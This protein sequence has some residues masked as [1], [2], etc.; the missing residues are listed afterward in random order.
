MSIPI[1]KKLKTAFGRAA[2]AAG[3][4]TR[5]FRSK[6]VI[7]AF[8]RVNDR[9]QNNDLTCG[10]EKF[11]QFCEFFAKHFTVI[12]LSEQIA[13]CTAN[14]NM[15]GTLA[16]TFDDGYRDNFDVAAP[17]LRRLRLPAA[18]F[19]TTRFIGSQF[20]PPWDSHLEVQPGWMD[21]GQVRAL[22][23]Q[24]FEIGCHTDS[25]IDMGT[26]E[27]GT[28][29]RELEAAKRK[30]RDELD[31]SVRLFAYPFGGRENMCERSRELVREAGFACC[32]S[33]YGGVNATHADPFR[34]NRIPIGNWFATP[35]QLG[36]ELIAGAA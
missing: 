21:W 1:R 26:A 9:I 34:L 30:L 8:H 23:S 16:I 18:F 22:V 35:N 20:V 6:L 3:M 2:G 31:S 24:G 14:K 11:Q 4:Y 7:V 27:A 13:G 25:H 36:Y 19:V 5:G 32:L 29:G 15:G 33:C 12:P 17:I 28:V 10:T